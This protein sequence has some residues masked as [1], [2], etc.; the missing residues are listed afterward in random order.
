ML[1]GRGLLGT[2]GPTFFDAAMALGPFHYVRLGDLSGTVVVAA[3]GSNIAYVGVVA[4]NQPGLVN[5]EPAQPSI[6]LTGTGTVDYTVLPG[7]GLD[8]PSG[9]QG[10][11]MAIWFSPLSLPQSFGTLIVDEATFAMYVNNSSMEFYFGG[12]NPASV[13]LI[14]GNTYF[15]LMTY[16]GLATVRM[17]QNG[18]NVGNVSVTPSSIINPSFTEAGRN[19]IGGEAFSGN[20]QELLIYD[21]E[22]SPTEQLDLYS[23]G[24]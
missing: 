21:Y 13:P 1:V 3:V 20:L 9:A 19:S 23:A 8:V 10:W 4:L 22:L 18:V 17:Y 5:S 2:K 7:A 11:T 12:S 24:I 6:R 14:A 16:D 15:G